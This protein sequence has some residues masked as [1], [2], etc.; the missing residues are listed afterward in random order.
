[1]P[2]DEIVAAVRDHLDARGF[3]NV[4]LDVLSAFHHSITPPDHPVVRAVLATLR[5]WGAEAEVWPIQPGGGPWTVVANEFGVPCIRGGAVGGGAAGPDDEF[6]VI[7][8]DGR[9]AGLAESEQFHVDAL[10]A[11]AGT[12]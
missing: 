6:L 12:L 10:Y 4:D 1:M 11:V 5:D 2:P 9:V 3:A 7:E 8:G